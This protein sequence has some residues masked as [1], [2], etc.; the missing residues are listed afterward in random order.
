MRPHN[1][2]IL[3]G[4]LRGDNR[5]ISCL[6]R[7]VLTFSDGGMGKWADAMAEVTLN[8]GKMIIARLLLIMEIYA[9]NLDDPTD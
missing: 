3:A 6:L 2:L 7:F 1:E 8:Y 9:A 4:I 5:V